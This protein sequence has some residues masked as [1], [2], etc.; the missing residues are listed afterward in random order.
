VQRAA[1]VAAVHKHQCPG[2]HVPDRTV[3]VLSTMRFTILQAVTL[4]FRKIIA[5]PGN[6]MNASNLTTAVGPTIFPTL[7]ILARP[8]PPPVCGPPLGQL[9]RCWRWTA[10]VQKTGIIME[11]L[12][13]YYPDIFTPEIVELVKSSQAA[14]AAARPAAEPPARPQPAKPTPAHGVGKVPLAPG[15]WVRQAGIACACAFACVAPNAH[16]HGWWRRGAG[17]RSLDGW[18]P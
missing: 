14:A 7:P 2:W 12:V 6:L 11:Y 16:A 10:R 18:H 5:T 8:Q 17:S 3:V 9:T 1:Q 13:V 4:L 15:V